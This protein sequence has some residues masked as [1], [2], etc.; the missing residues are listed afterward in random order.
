MSA[1]DFLC[2]D[3]ATPLLEHYT[4]AGAVCSFSTN[5]EAILEAARESFLPVGTPPL[6]VDFSVRF[7]VDHTHSAQPPW[8]KPYVRGL[9]HLVF[10]GFDSGSSMLAD[11][12]TRRVIGRFSA[13]MAADHSYWKTVIFPILLTTIGASVGIAEL[14][15]SCVANKQGGLLLVGPGRSGKSTLAVALA[16][17]GF[18]FLSDDRTF[19]SWRNGKLSAWGL[20]TT[21][22]L[23]GDAQAH[24]RELQSKRP[25]DLQ[26]GEPSF[27]LEPQSGLGLERARRCEPRLLVFLERSESPMFSLTDMSSEEAT[28]R[29]EADL[30]AELP[31]AAAMQAKVIARLTELPCRRLQYGGQPQEVAKEL[32]LHFDDCGPG[33]GKLSTKRMGVPVSATNF[34]H[35]APIPPKIPAERIRQD[36]LRRFTPTPY[37]VDLLVMARTVRLESNSLAVVES[38]VE[39]FARHQGMSPAGPE[40]LWRIVSQENPQMEPVG[41]ALSAFSDRGLRFANIEQSSFLAVDLEAREGIGFVSERLVEGEPR[42][43]CRSI[44]DTLYCMSAGSLGIVPLSAACVGLGEKGLL[45]LGPP[46]SGKTTAS[47]L[48]AKL[49]LEFHSDQAVFSEIE[50]GRLRVWGD[51]LPA[52]FRLQ[53]LASLPELLPGT[54]RF[55]YPGLTVCYLPKRPFQAPMAHS[56]APVGC[57]FL[58]RQSATMPSLSPIAGMDLSRRIADSFLFKED[59]RF[60]Q[61]SEM[62]I[63]ALEKLPAYHLAYGSDPATTVPLLQKVLMDRDLLG[64][65]EQPAPAR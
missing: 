4:V 57:V 35:E 48:A 12:R 43:T 32:A 3:A 30:V 50:G 55:S 33:N 11:P 22:K 19:C 14:H 40:F 23:R 47:Y 62:V 21:L 28:A 20:A 61:Q 41:V 38:A 65:H 44:F 56:V 1:G 59:D 64:D 60:A 46:N 16:Q 54:R 63:R 24:F 52:I 7:W 26:N 45:I 2:Q 9:N 18:A 34:P 6:A 10:A 8:P 13:S 58:E 37:G 51:L 42:Q 53:S 29:L 36:L 39:F 5:C 27:R 17:A 49:G 31:E 15:C 25:T